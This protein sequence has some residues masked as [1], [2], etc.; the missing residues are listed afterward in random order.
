MSDPPIKPPSVFH[1]DEL[2]NNPLFA[3]GLGLAGLGAAAAIARKAAI[4]GAFLIKRRLLVNLEINQQDKSYPWI[5]Q[6][7]SMPRPSNDF[8][9]LTHQDHLP[10]EA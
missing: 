3:G 2:F 1:L 7:L 6:W 4:R 10:I 8:I 5:L 9:S